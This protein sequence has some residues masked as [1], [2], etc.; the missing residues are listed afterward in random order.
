MTNAIDKPTTP[1]RNS[2]AVETMVDHHG[3]RI[4]VRAHRDGCDRQAR[5]HDVEVD[6]ATGA[7]RA[8][9]AGSTGCHVEYLRIEP[10][11]TDDAD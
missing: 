6:P 1:A 2:Q 9:C 7:T 10:A 8:V 4:T 3:N 11:G 5:P